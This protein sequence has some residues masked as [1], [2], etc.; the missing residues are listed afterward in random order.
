MGPVCDGPEKNPNA[1]LIR[2][3]HLRVGRP[4]RGLKIDSL[5]EGASSSPAVAP[6][7]QMLVRT[8]DVAPLW[9]LMAIKM[10]FEQAAR[11]AEPANPVPS[12][13]SPGSSSPSGTSATR[14]PASPMRSGAKGWNLACRPASDD[15]NSR[16]AANVA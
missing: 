6:S 1:R 10:R 2:P 7:N 14:E 15:S 8:V 12:I 9:R 4:L 3:D 5:P 16:L 11:S 13:R